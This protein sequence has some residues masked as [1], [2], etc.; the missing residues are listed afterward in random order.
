M[1]KF[2]ASVGLMKRWQQQVKATVREFCVKKCRAEQDRR[3]DIRRF[4]AL[5]PEAERITHMQ[6]DNRL[7]DCVCQTRTADLGSSQKSL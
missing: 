7:E 1:A 2:I 6:K 4:E 3:S 5:V